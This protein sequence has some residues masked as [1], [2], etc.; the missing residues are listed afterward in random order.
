M[1]FSD[2]QKTIIVSLMYVFKRLLV[3]W[4]PKRTSLYTDV[5]VHLFSLFAGSNTLMQLADIKNWAVE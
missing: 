4:R 3:K 2:N 1:K 5:L